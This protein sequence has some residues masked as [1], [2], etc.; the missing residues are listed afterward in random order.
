MPPALGW[1]LGV[2]LFMCY[3]VKATHETSLKLREFVFC[4]WM[5]LLELRLKGIFLS[6]IRIWYEK[7]VGKK[8]EIYKWW[9]KSLSLLRVLS[10]GRE[11]VGKPRQW[12]GLHQ[13]AVIG[14]GSDTVSTR[15][16]LIFIDWRGFL[17]PHAHV[18]ITITDTLGFVQ[19][20]VTVES[21]DIFHTWKHDALD[22]RMPWHVYLLICIEFFVRLIMRFSIFLCFTCS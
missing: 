4:E 1:C 7:G 6:Q 2:A 17:Q 20:S 14:Q 11:A 22:P 8:S 5:C 15:V 12:A 10:A 21:L 13:I 18:Y 9:H 16:S 19:F 3:K